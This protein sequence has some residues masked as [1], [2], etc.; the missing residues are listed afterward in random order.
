M[1]S[2][3]GY[4]D[5]HCNLLITFWSRC[6]VRDDWQLTIQC[7][8]DV[9]FLP[10]CDTTLLMYVHWCATGVSCGFAYNELLNPRWGCIG[11]VRRGGGWDKYSYIAKNCLFIRLDCFTQVNLICILLIL[12]F[13]KQ[14]ILHE[15][16]QVIFKCNC[17][18]NYTV[19][20]P[21]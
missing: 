18:V 13:I 6:C 1:F 21:A 17:G 15:V 4:D 12:D 3:A 16:T 5:F 7:T 14:V 11:W 9:P 2:V 20:S 8:C 19:H 10:V